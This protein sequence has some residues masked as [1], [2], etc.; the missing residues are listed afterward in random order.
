M[1]TINTTLLRSCAI[2]KNINGVILEEG[3]EVKGG[4]FSLRS[5]I[6]HCVCGS[7]RI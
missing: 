1:G 2:K 4:I 7:G 6:V 5:E 3:Y